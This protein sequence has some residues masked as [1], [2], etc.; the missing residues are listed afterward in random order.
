V[1]RWCRW[2]CRAPEPRMLIENEIK[3]Q[4]TRV[5]ELDRQHRKAF[6][7]LL[8]LFDWEIF[9]RQHGYYEVGRDIPYGGEPNGNKNN[10]E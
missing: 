9:E 6:Q 3:E 8:N 10:S 1:R 4:L 5:R 7:R 2:L